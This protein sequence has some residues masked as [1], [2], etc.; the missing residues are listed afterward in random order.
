M[1][2]PQKVVGEFYERK[3]ADILGLV[4]VD[5]SSNGEI[6]DLMEKNGSYFVQ[7]KASSF[8]NGG[9][10]KGKQL[11]KFGELCDTRKFYALAFHTITENMR[12]SYATAEDLRKALD[13]K[14]LFILPFSIVEAFYNCSNKKPYPHDNF[15]QINEITA[16][17][18]FLGDGEVWEKLGLDKN[19][20]YRTG[21]HRKIYLITNTGNLEMEII[22]SINK[23]KI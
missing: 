22:K 2:N 13:L 3:V 21:V 16:L 10:I 14:S 7:V 6:A 18:I 5:K 9:V 17:K 15:V 19:K 4:P 23:N 11:A 8:T 12:K 20:Y 1:R